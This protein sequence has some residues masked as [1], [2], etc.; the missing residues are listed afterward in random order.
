MRVGVR[1]DIGKIRRSNQDSYCITSRLFAVADG[2]GG[3]RAG[4]VASAMAV[5]FLKRYQFDDAFPEE[6]LVSAVNEANRRIFDLASQRPEYAGMG[7]TL[8]AA[9][10]IDDTVFIGHVGDSRAYLI[11]NGAITQLTNDHSIVGELLRS[12]SLTEEEAMNHPQRNLLIQALGTDE[13]VS[14]E[15]NRARI[16]IDDAVVLCTDGLSSLV[17]SEEIRDVVVA[18]DDPQ[19]AA[20]ELTEMA[21][22]RGGH[23]NITVI[24]IYILPGSPSIESAIEDAIRLEESVPCDS[25]LCGAGIH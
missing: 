15:I 6:S 19:K 4:E 12:G 14:V 1:T 5:E 13:K 11:A 21:L 9:L 23:D 18:T 7:T 24:V 20:D 10:F 22:E 2:M 25:P 8:T 3:S 16:S 17:S